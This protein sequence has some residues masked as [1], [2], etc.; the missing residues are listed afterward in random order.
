SII[1]AE[2]LPYYASVGPGP[3]R[4]RAGYASRRA[5]CFWTAA[6]PAVRVLSNLSN[7]K[8]TDTSR[9]PQAANPLIAAA[10]SFPHGTDTE[11]QG[12]RPM[13]PYVPDACEK[14]RE[15][16]GQRAASTLGSVW[17]GVIR[18]PLRPSPVATTSPA[19][20][21]KRLH[22]LNAVTRLRR[23]GLVLSHTLVRGQGPQG[24]SHWGCRRRLAAPRF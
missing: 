12:H 3:S 15:N 23:R 20:R 9:A 5:G 1:R 19:C 8:L 2:V 11:V 14:R 10:N 24:L 6:Q 21:R 13:S 16:E 7:S 4:S 17:M 22:S 18:G